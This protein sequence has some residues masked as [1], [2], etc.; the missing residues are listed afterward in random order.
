MVIL[1]CSVGPGQLAIKAL[2]REM[3]FVKAGLERAAGV[4][5]PIAALLNCSSTI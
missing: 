1:Y 3:D 4:R 2:F 5:F